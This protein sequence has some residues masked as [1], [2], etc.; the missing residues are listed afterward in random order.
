[1]KNILYYP[2]INLP[3][4]NWTIRSLL[5]YDKVGS[6]VPQDYFQNPEKYDPSMR[7]LVQS[8][9]VNP[10]DPMSVF[11]YPWEVFKTFLD[12]VEDNR[13]ILC[14]RRFYISQSDPRKGVSHIHVDKFSCSQNQIPKGQYIGS[15]IHIGKFESVIFDQL[16]QMGLAARKD[17]QWYAVEKKTAQE[18]M[19]FLANVI[20]KKIGYQPTTDELSLGLKIRLNS[21]ETEYKA[22]YGKRERILQELIP[23]PEQIDVGKLIKFKE[24]HEKALEAFR[25][26]VELIVLDPNI[27]ENSELFSEKVKELN[28]RKEELLAKMNENRFGRVFYGS[29]CGI[30]GAGIAFPVCGNMGAVIGA[31]PGFAHS[32]YSALRIERVENIPDQT[33]LKYLA[34][35][36]KKLRGGGFTLHKKNNGL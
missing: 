33:G 36:D 15:H 21:G 35:V 13:D 32:I 20:G 27:D 1:M 14:K 4:T 8:E 3:R 11:D 28:L 7:E 29:I 16:S 22:K 34:L 30:I 5:Y 25:N 12:Y 10:I 17:D 31:L 18:L 6:I 19:I 26:R 23:F 2:Y 9:L 24:K